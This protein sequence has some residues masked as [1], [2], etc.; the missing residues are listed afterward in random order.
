KRWTPQAGITREP[1]PDSPKVEETFSKRTLQLRSIGRDFSA[2]SKDPEQ[3]RWELRL[4]PKPLYRYEKPQ[5]DVI[6]GAL[7]ALVSDAGTD[8][9]VILILEAQRNSVGETAWYYRPIRMSISDLNVD[10]KGNRVWT[11]LRDDP[12]ALL[13]NKDETYFILRD[14]MIDELPPR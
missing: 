11:S 8:P 10:Y 7:L 9:E 12:E 3:R 2:N 6:D 1:L 4:L 5:G 14:R 13:S